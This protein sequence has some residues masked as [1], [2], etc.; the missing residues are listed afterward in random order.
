[1]RIN[2]S[3][4]SAHEEPPRHRRRHSNRMPKAPALRTSVVW[5]LAAREARKA[6]EAPP[7]RRAGSTVL[8][9]ADSRSPGHRHRPV[10]QDRLSRLRGDLRVT[11]GTRKPRQRA[12]FT[13]LMA[14]PQRSKVDSTGS[15]LTSDS[16][17]LH[18][19]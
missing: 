17:L 7:R 13:R 11:W 8:A 15:E 19:R 5:V 10:D 6:V 12:H 3:K 1:M 14:L 9:Q 2:T 18:L 4:G 16:S